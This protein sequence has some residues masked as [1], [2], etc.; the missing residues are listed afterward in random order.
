M[1]LFGKKEKQKVEVK[2][3]VSETP[4]RIDIRF[5]HTNYEAIFALLQELIKDGKLPD[6]KNYVYLNCR[7]EDEDGQ[8]KVYAAKSGKGNTYRCIG[9]VPGEHADSVLKAELEKVRTKKYFWSLS[10]YYHYINACNFQLSL[11]ESK[12]S[13]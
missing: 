6:L 8:L 13:K 5:D 1:A 10:L 9:T 12:F 7:I 2:T 11:K 3:T 4:D